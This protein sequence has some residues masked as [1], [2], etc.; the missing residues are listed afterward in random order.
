GSFTANNKPYDGT[1]AATIATWSV[2]GVIA[3]DTVTPS[4]G[5]ATFA[6]ANVGTG[7][8]VTAQTTFTLGGA[9]GGNYSLA[10]GSIATT[11]ANITAAISFTPSDLP[12]TISDT[13]PLGT[14]SVL[15]LVDS[16]SAT[17]TAASTGD[18]TYPPGDTV[19]LTFSWSS[20]AGTLKNTRTGAT[21]KIK[22]NDPK[23]GTITCTITATDST[24]S[25]TTPYTTGGVA[26]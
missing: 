24:R 23:G 25:L 9:Q 26:Y 8:V 3:G 16:K 13:P 21:Y 22:G 2:T 6:G 7:I 1:T 12:I 10:V 5:T 18:L 19:T 15:S 4:G 14:N 17:F 20:T 11:T